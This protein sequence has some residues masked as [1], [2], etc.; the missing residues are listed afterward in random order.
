MRLVQKAIIKKGECFLVLRRSPTAA[1]FPNYW[2]FPGG[3]LEAGE[4]PY[5]GIEREILEETGLKAKA[6]QVVG[7]YE[8]D[9]DNIGEITHKF[10]VYAAKVT[11]DKNKIRLSHEHSGFRWATKP[12]ILN[13]KIELYMRE[14]FKEHP[15]LF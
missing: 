15:L 5:T 9:L 3:G 4:E 14:Y 11:S 13:M 2:D 6:L 7:E 12:Q 8:L 1:Y 10:T